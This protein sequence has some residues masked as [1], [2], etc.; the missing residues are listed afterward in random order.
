MNG[1]EASATRGA[2]KP[3]GRL[4][5]MV[6]AWLAAGFALRFIPGLAAFWPLWPWA[7]ALIGLAAVFDAWRLM[8][9]TPGIE[10]E[11]RMPGNWPVN[12]PVKLTLEV[13]H[14]GHRPLRVRLHELHP[15]WVRAENM[16]QASVIAPGEQLYL[17]WRATSIRRGEFLLP[18]CHLEWSG[19]LGLSRRRRT[20]ISGDRVRVYPNFNLVVQYGLLAGDRRLDEM[21]IHLKPRRGTGS[22]FH[23]LREYRE[24]D[25]LRQIDWHATARTRKLISKEYQE[26]RN[27]RVVFLLDCSRRMR[28]MDGALSHFDH[29]LNAML[30]L[31][32]VALKQ[33]DEVALHTLAAPGGE[34][35]VPPGRGQRQYAEVLESV[36]DLEAG[37]SHPDFLGAAGKLMNHQRRRGLIILLTNLR[38]EDHDEL[39]PALR[40]LRQRH[41]LVLADLRERIAAAPTARG[42]PR[43]VT[44]FDDALLQAA[45][46]LYR[47]QRKTATRH[48]SQFGVIHLDV[49]PDALPAAL[50]SQYRTLKA[51]GIL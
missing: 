11:R 41:L 24:G 33:G 22:D 28:A 48:L 2:L 36:F 42:R 13:T 27:Q 35:V 7:G 19:P 49:T 40:L 4:L 1:G 26:E 15:P 17:P 44:G 43:E 6:G 51:G 23:Q 31:S 29:C 3:A 30:L 50:V 45:G 32:H 8:R 37:T 20:V 5:G 46:A 16:P 38:D 18:G 21:G 9:E 12:V 10:I 25:S 14:R 39:L 34:R 47:E